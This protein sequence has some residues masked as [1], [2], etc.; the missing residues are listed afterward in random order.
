MMSRKLRIAI[1]AGALVVAAVGL[2]GCG[3]RGDASSP[4]ASASEV[5]VTLLVREIEEDYV[6]QFRVGDSVRDRETRALLGTIESVE[7]TV[8]RRPVETA[9]GEIVLAEIPEALDMR[10]VVRGEASIPDSGVRFGNLVVYMNDDLNLVLPRLL[11]R[12]KVVT[13][14]PTS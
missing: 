6:P 2:G 13:I 10:V 9:D 7:T 4:Q 11:F 5:R 14:E 3:V 1:L 8:A 12:A